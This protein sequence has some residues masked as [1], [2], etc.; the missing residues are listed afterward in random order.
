M[1]GAKS[2]PKAKRV[3]KATPKSAQPSGKKNAYTGTADAKL[4]LL[5]MCFK[6][7]EGPTDFKAVGQAY[8]ISATAAQYRYYRL[9]DFMEKQDLPGMKKAPAGNDE[10][11]VEME[12]YEE[13][14]E[15]EDNQEEVDFGVLFE[16]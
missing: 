2:T 14:A 7:K 10:D 6:N 12:D 4:V 16:A 1:P 8:G 3:S 15:D 5:Y 13:Q 11:S 9:R